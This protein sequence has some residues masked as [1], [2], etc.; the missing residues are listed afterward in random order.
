MRLLLR[1]DHHRAFARLLQR[2]KRGTKKP[3]PKGRLL[4]S[5]EVGPNQA[6]PFWLMVST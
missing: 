2:K 3:P 5:I 6:Q 4:E 1:F